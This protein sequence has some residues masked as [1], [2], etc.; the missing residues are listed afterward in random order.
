[1]DI[2]LSFNNLAE[3][4]RLPVLPQEFTA[5]TGLNNKTVEVIGLGELGIIGNRKLHEITIESF[6]PK[7]YSSYCRYKNIPEPYDAVGLISKW[8]DTKRPIRLNITETPINLPCM[9]ESWE[10]G[11]RGGQPGDIYFTLKLKEYRFI[12]IR[13]ITEENGQ[14]KTNDDRPD[15]RETPKTYI[16]KEG[17]N[18]LL[19]CKRIYGGD[20][21]L[22]DFY[23]KN[24]ETIG[25]DPDL[26]KPGQVLYT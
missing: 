14:L 7:H 10:H 20:G 2:Y 25:P 4:L 19:I 3:V 21:K 26:I 22:N 9:I 23:E 5:V 6:F 13:K 11:Q 24:K 12:N 15:E 16:V 18:L 8:R 17:D 1:M